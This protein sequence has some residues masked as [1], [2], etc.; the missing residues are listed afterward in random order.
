[1][2]NLFSRY[3]SYPTN[4]WD[5]VGKFSMRNERCTQDFPLGKP[6]YGKYIKVEMVN[7]FGQEHYCPI[8][9]IRVFGST[10]MEEY[11]YTESQREQREDEIGD[12][13][14]DEF[15]TIDTDQG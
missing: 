11:E 15:K 1:M 2:Y 6:A 14:D 13:T 10:M 5:K 9:M 12:E 4:K 7:H 8:S 3:H